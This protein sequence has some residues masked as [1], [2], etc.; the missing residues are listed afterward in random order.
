LRH[1][2]PPLPLAAGLVFQGIG[3]ALVILY[4]LAPAAGIALAWVHA[5]A[6]GWLTLTALSV[7]LFVIP[8]FTDLR[9]HGERVAR[10]AVAALPVGIVLLVVG[11]AAGL[12]AVL[13]SGAVIAVVAIAA[14]FVLALRTLAQ[15][16]AERT[17]AAIA[18]A[19]SVA[20]SMLTVTAVLGLALAFAY[21]AGDAGVLRLAPSHALIGIAAWLTVLISGVSVQT[22]RPMLGAR[23]RWRLAHIASGA[24]LLLG[25]VIGAAG[26]PVSVTV[27]RIGVVLAALGAVVY[28]VDALDIVRRATTPHPPVR[29]FVAAA[30]G[31][32]LIA[33]VCMVAA[34]WSTPLDG[35]AGIAPFGGLAV[36]AGLA[37]WAGGMVNAHLHHLGVRVVI[38]LIRGDDDE[39]RPWDVLNPR[40]TW[41]AFT[42]GQLAVL[43][44]VLGLLTNVPVVFVAGG[45]A[46]LASIACIVANVLTVLR[47]VRATNPVVSLV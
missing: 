5:V 21:A 8:A 33:A 30:V 12:A 31:W 37:G 32:L 14:Y 28:A 10:A 2:I 23:S 24:S 27:M 44:T 11:F 34:A 4:G 20:L 45:S 18:R 6:L 9:W 40:L 43:A 46:G 3:W 25:A 22:F 26:A 1:W 36:V 13:E 39:T 41:A 47:T 17:E 15:R 38:T 42:F 19:L 16:A 35:A 29:A 7:L